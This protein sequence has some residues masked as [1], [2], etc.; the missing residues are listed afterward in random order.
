MKEPQVRNLPKSNA[1]DTHDYD[2]GEM[3]RAAEQAA[4]EATEQALA[5]VNESHH[6][7]GVDEVDRT[8]E[9][10]KRHIR[11][12]HGAAQRD[13][14]YTVDEI[15]RI[16]KIVAMYQSNR[17]A[18]IAMKDEAQDRILKARFALARFV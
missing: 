12:A 17:A 18:L 9:D 16:D 7:V 14:Q 15:E 11:A 1:H 8:R 6:T 3:D 13:H 10:L 2:N 4:I 5:E